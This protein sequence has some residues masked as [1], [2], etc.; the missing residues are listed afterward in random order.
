MARKPLSLRELTIGLTFQK[1]PIT[2][3]EHR[4][5]EGLGCLL[6]KI[7]PGIDDAVFMHPDK[8][9]GVVSRPTRL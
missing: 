8:H 1:E 6:R 9:V 5:G 7:M 2:N 3:L 4:V